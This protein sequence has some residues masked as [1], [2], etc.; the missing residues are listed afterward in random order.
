MPEMRLAVMALKTSRAACNQIR[1]C[2][3]ALNYAACSL[4]TQACHTSCFSSRIPLGF[5]TAADN[6]PPQA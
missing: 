4:A 5:Q 6:A 1:R 3:G 2:W